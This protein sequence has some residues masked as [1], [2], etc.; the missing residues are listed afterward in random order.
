MEKLQDIQKQIND[1]TKNQVVLVKQLKDIKNKFNDERIQE[2]YEQG[3]QN[4]DYISNLQKQQYEAEHDIIQLLKQKDKQ[5]QNHNSKILV[6]EQ[7]I[8]KQ[9]EF[10]EDRILNLEQDLQTKYQYQLEQQQKKMEEQQQDLIKKQQE[11]QH[12]LQKKQELFQQLC[13]KQL[14]NLE[15]AK[16]TNSLRKMAVLNNDLDVKKDFSKQQYNN[17]KDICGL[18]SD[19]EKVSNDIKKQLQKQFQQQIDKLE[20]QYLDSQQQKREEFK[21][22]QKKVIELN[23]CYLIQKQK[24]EQ[25][26]KVKE[27]EKKQEAQR[28]KEIKRQEISQLSEIMKIDK[29]VN[30]LVISL[31]IKRNNIISDQGAKHISKAIENLSNLSELRLFLE[32]LNQFKL[33][34]QLINQKEFEKAQKLCEELGQN[35]GFL[36]QSLELQAQIQEKQRNFQNAL[37]IYDKILYKVDEN[38]P[39]VQFKQANILMN[40]Q[41]YK[42]CLEGYKKALIF[43]GR[44]KTSPSQKNSNNQHTHINVIDYEQLEYLCNLNISISYASLRD[45]QQ[46]ISYADICIRQKPKDPKGYIQ[47]GI[48]L[49]ILKYYKDAMENYNKALEYDP[50]NKRANEAK[51]K[52]KKFLQMEKYNHILREGQNL[53]GIKKYGEAI[54]IFDKCIEMDPQNTQG[55]YLKGLCYE[56]M[57]ILDEALQLYK[58]C[59]RLDP[60]DAMIY[61]KVGTI[62]DELK[63]YQEANI[64]IEKA[65]LLNP[66]NEE[67][68]FGKFENLCNMVKFDE[69]EKCLNE[70]I[71][72]FPQS[73][74]FKK[75]QEK[76]QF[77]RSNSKEEWQQK[78]KVLDNLSVQDI[79]QEL[80]KENG[81]EKQEK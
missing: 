32:I 55:H 53:I 81:Q 75:I 20:Q 80:E 33:T 35:K 37:E 25:L 66:V 19:P 48:Y 1:I 69:A 17:K 21:N 44:L 70:A 58:Q 39:L 65:Y 14:I 8:N 57:D 9:K 7:D 4:Y 41:K 10:Y 68:L 62:M 18:E 64:F 56:N 3:Q 43:L 72:H 54:Q 11:Q 47:K 23:K 13:Q 61:L 77:Y 76:F 74:M 40:T 22:L 29:N 24:N 63:Q 45:Y 15:K 38:N 52:L 78:K 28:K 42:E 34:Q 51:D 12:Q 46:A 2:I 6:L 71:E 59:I 49:E 27:E 36:G 79:Q 50:D 60:N 5:I 31:S 30:I 73:D 16:K 26:I 67:I